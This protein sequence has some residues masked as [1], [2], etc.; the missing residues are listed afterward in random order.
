VGDPGLR[1]CPLTMLGLTAM[2]TG[3]LA[4]ATSHLAEALKVAQSVDFRY[5]VSSALVS[6]AALA[7]KQSHPA[8]AVRLAAASD[9]ILET[10]APDASESVKPRILGPAV[11]ASDRRGSWLEKS[12]NELGPERSAKCWAEGR[13]MS[14][15]RAVEYALTDE[16]G[17]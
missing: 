16:H 1:T 3:D 10:V 5:G 6:F 2:E 8:R 17:G 7:A 11:F 13:S 15:D 14:R 12:Q 4:S 9:L